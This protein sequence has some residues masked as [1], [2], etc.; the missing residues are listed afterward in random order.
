LDI[1]YARIVITTRRSP[2]WNTQCHVS[3][4]SCFCS[5]VFEINQYSHYSNAV[6]GV[7]TLG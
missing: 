4:S 5:F 7:G 2:F 6:S 3:G 1:S